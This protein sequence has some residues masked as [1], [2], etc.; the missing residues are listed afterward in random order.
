MIN[1]RGKIVLIT[2]GY[3]Y[4]GKSISNGLKDHGATLVVLARDRNKYQDAFSETKGIHF[5]ECDV[6]STE[7]VKYAFS[8][9]VK[10]HGKID[11]LINNAFYLEGQSPLG[12][13]DEEFACSMDGVIGSV[14]RCI[15]EVVPYFE[16]SE[17]NK[18]INISSMYGVIAPD[19]EIYND[20][21]EYLN[22]P[23]Y[24]IGKAGLIQ[25]TKYFAS[26]LGKK[27]IQVNA[28]SP[29]P[30]PS[31]NVKKNAAFVKSLE[32]KTALKRVGVPEDLTGVFV[33]LCSDY[34][35]YI[36]GQNLIV[37]GGWTII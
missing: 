25:M 9:V 15:R 6:S 13:S 8:Q 17:A 24:G 30:F 5:M 14:Y 16:S 35:N 37:D 20:A 28:V 7:S 33:L 26:F 18:I 11:C 12:I 34:S 21:P 4:L 22:P 3:G 23:H 2:G 32:Q 29:G 10:Q 31:E 27:N 36:T 19:F 1:L